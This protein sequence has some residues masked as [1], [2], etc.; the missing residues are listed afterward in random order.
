MARGVPISGW[1]G[2][3]VRARAPTAGIS[4]GNHDPH[5]DPILCREREVDYGPGGEESIIIEPE[6]DYRK[7]RKA[8]VSNEIMKAPVEFCFRTSA[9]NQVSTPLQR[10]SLTRVL[11]ER[12][13]EQ[14]LACFRSHRRLLDFALLRHNF[15]PRYVSQ[16]LRNFNRTWI[17]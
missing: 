4:P 1:H 11:A 7:R 12:Y 16:I 2:V 5:A 10:V 3:Q 13:Y 6:D 9:A 17:A 14:A 15:K 8:S